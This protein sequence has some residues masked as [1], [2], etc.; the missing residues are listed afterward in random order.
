[1][2]FV[3]LG[4][5]GLHITPITYGTA[6]TIG[7]ES[8]DV[9]YARKMIETAWELGIRSFDVSNNYG[10][11]QAEVLLGKI[12]S[13]YPRQEYVLSTKGS[14]QIGESIYH[15]GL[16]RKHVIWA[17]ENS[18]KR[19]NIE[20]VD[21]YYAHRYDPNVPME[22]IVRTFN[23]LIDGGKVRYWGTSEWPASALKECHAV[24]EELKLEKPIVEQCFY[25]YAVQK[26]ETNGVKEFCNSNGVGLLAFGPLAQGTLTGKYLDGIPKGSRIDKSNA[27]NYDKTANIYEQ[28]KEIIAKFIKLCREYETQPV[29][30]ALQWCIKEKV[31]PVLGASTTNQ[32]KENID[33]LQQDIS[34]ELLEDMKKL[35]LE[36]R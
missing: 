34:F 14:W 7:T 18:L 4:K 20:Y 26:I 22:E 35:W 10:D 23:H 32:L 31:Y 19:L 36:S 8:K 21:I 28:N 6:L 2:D 12:M 9:F 3:R 29:A 16:S 17:F 33:S 27:I 13:T 25:S 5:S 24:C 30:A 11:G 15:G 1:M